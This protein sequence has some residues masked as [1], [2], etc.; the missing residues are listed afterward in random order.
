MSLSGT[1]FSSAGSRYG[2]FTNLNNASTANLGTAFQLI[3][4]AGNFTKTRGDTAIEVRLNSYIGVTDASGDT[5]EIQIRLGTAQPTLGGRLMIRYN[6]ANTFH[7]MDGVFTSLPAGTYS[8]Q[9]WARAFSG[10]V[11]S[12]LL[13][14]SGFRD[15]IMVK[16]VR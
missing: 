14:P 11:D 2:Y 3:H 5:A 16:E 7:S 1:T 10:V 9:V 8:V 13:D 12:I 6:Q 15:H 4:T